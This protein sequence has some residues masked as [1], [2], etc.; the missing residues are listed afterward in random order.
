MAFK[1][2]WQSTVM[3]YNMG[4]IIQGLFASVTIFLPVA[5]ADYDV[6]SFNSI[7][8]SFLSM[9]IVVLPLFRFLEPGFDPEFGNPGTGTAEWVPLLSM[10]LLT[11]SP[12]FVFIAK[13]MWQHTFQVLKVSHIQLT[14]SVFT[15]SLSSS[16]LT[17][18]CMAV[19]A[20]NW[21]PAVACCASF[22]ISTGPNLFTRA[23]DL[24]VTKSNNDNDKYLSHTMKTKIHT[25]VHYPWKTIHVLSCKCLLR[26]LLGG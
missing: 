5:P 26:L 6:T 3:S 18:T 16:C 15:H 19:V 2:V 8:C 24:Q 21:H 25:F 1:R 12:D 22:L 20:V 10:Y 13:M 9:N 17:M 11:V 4:W 23:D 14:T 7:N